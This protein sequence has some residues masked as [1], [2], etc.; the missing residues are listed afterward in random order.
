MCYYKR[1]FKEMYFL[2]Y[3]AEVRKAVNVPLAYLGGVRSAANVEEAMREG[4][5][6]VAMARPFLR[7]P[8]L[9]LKWQKN[10]TRESLCDNCNSCIAYIYHK[11]GTRCVYRPHNSEQLNKIRASA[12]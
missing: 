10:E 6:A 5:D 1:E 2:K 9:T 4:F 7:E 3:S 11:D 12:H 8:D